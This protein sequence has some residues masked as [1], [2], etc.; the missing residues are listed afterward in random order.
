M[1]TAQRKGTLRRKLAD[2]PRP[3]WAPMIRAF[4]DLPELKKAHTVLL[5]YG[6]G[7][8]P[9]TEPLIAELLRRG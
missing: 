7:K 3:D 8:E 4:L 6:V 9:D 1:N 5:F 2:L